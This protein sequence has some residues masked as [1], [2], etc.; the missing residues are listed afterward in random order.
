[1]FSRK[2]WKIHNLYHSISKILQELIKNGTYPTAY[3]LL[4]VRGLWQTLYQILVNNRSEGIYKIKYKY[5]DN[6]KKC[7]TCGIK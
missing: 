4:I 2:H 5:R 3:N 6:D 1:M 7:V